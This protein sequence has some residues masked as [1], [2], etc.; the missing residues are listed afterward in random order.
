MPSIAYG[1][2]NSMIKG[3]LHGI[4]G[5]V[6]SN[7]VP[8]PQALFIRCSEQ[9]EHQAPYVEPSEEVSGTHIY[10]G[11][12]FPHF[13]HFI[14]ENLSRIWYAKRHPELKIVWT[15][16]NNYLPWQKEILE[17]L[18]I[19]NQAFFV[20]SPTRFSSL[21]VPSSGYAAPGFLAPYHL[22]A[23][24]VIEPKEVIPG[25]KIYISRSRMPSTHGG[26][27]NEAA[28]EDIL[29]KQGW[30][31][32]HPQEHPVKTRFDEISSSEV[33]LLIDGAAFASFIFFRELH[34]KI[35]SMVRLDEGSPFT[36][37]LARKKSFR[38]TVLRV[39]KNV[40]AGTGPQARSELDLT[41]FKEL[42][43]KTNFLSGDISCIED[44]CVPYR[45]DHQALITQFENTLNTI[46]TRCSPER[47]YFYKSVLFEKEG[48]L[49]RAVAEIGK[50]I[51]ARNT[52]P[53][54]HHHLARFLVRKGDFN[55]AA[56]AQQRA[57]LLDSEKHPLFHVELSRIYAQGDKLDKAIE[58]AKAA[59]GLQ[60]DN[61]HFHHHLGNL[62]MQKGDLDGAEAAQKK[63]IELDPESL[64]AHIQLSHIHARKS[65]LDKAIKEVEIAIGLQE[66]NPYLLHHFGNLLLQQG[67]V[68]SAEVAQRKT[69][70]LDP[71]IPGSHFQLS[72]IHA[73]RNELDKAIEEAETAIGLQEDNPHFHHHLGALLLQKEDLDGAEAAQRQAIELDP[74]LPGLQVQLDRIHA[75]KN[76]RDK[77]IEEK[78]R[79]NAREMN[80][81]FGPVL[82]QLAFIAE[83]DGR[84]R[85][86]F[87]RG[88]I[89]RLPGFRHSKNR[90][91]K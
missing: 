27:T 67:S 66:D 61:P 63:A 46:K 87:W 2:S 7:G 36:D 12:L 60:E 13:A 23:L 26:Y 10:C 53:L 68:D 32:F 16:Q 11:P 65:E 38:Y 77:A 19:K 35:F 69:V 56:K 6:Y 81:Y 44:L 31:I 71:R 45:W 47:E 17:I 49:D 75:R 91:R 20:D 9:V 88:L 89:D 84:Y 42:L 4:L 21:I 79:K 5:G 86:G 48:D 78:V 58:E 22:D 15:L 52:T 28:M 3:A 64:D 34:S 62:L 18:G 72:H 8:I 39:P 54:L 85:A 74:N 50:A 40:Q 76:E 57:M 83:E 43:Q 70:E 37:I 55:G 82:R 73:G 14:L 59:I 80:F 24:G 33:V 1:L 90:L 41:V 25:K 51:T 30:K 29:E